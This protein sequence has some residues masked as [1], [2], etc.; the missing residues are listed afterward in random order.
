M[1]T[2]DDKIED[3]YATNHQLHDTVTHLSYSYRVDEVR[4]GRYTCLD[5][6]IT[7]LNRIALVV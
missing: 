5:T 2:I 1:K 3:A 7:Q 6:T 4:D